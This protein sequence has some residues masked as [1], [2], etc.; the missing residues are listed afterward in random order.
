MIY[1][2]IWSNQQDILD[3][4]YELMPLLQQYTG[5]EPSVLTKNSFVLVYGKQYPLQDMD[6][7]WESN[8]AIL[9]GRIFDKVLHKAVEKKEFSK[10]SQKLQQGLTEEVW[11]KYVYW[12]IDN[13]DKIEVMTDPAGQLSCFYY[14]LPSGGLLF[15]SHIELIKQCLSSKLDYNW[16]YLCSYLSY[17]DSC[18]TQTPFK[19]IEEVPPGCLLTA[20]HSSRQ[21]RPFWNPF[22]TYASIPPYSGNAVDAL[23]A[24]LR[25]IT[26]PYQNLCVS[27]SGGL[28]SSSL[29]YCLNEIKRPEQKLTA[30]NYFH[31]SIK[32]SNELHY[33]RKICDELG[34]ELNEIDFSNTL[35]FDPYLETPSL[36]LN[37]PSSASICLASI[38]KI[39]HYFPSNE[40]SILLSGH[41]SDHIFSRPPVKRSLVD[42]LL[43]CGTRGL[44]GKIKYITHFYRDSFAPI[45]AQN[46][47]SLVRYFFARQSDKRGE[48][49]YKEKTPR[50]LMPKINQYITT[51]FVHP[52]YKD[53]PARILPGKYDQID[54]LYEA[55]AS[56]HAKANTY[57]PEH[58]PFLCEPVIHFALSFPTY[59]LFDKGYDRYPLRQAVSSRFKTDNVWRRDK[60]ET[61]GILQLGVK[62][63]IDYVMELCLEGELVK[64]GFVDKESLRQTILLISNGSY[65]DLW[66]FVQLASIEEFLRMWSLNSDKNQINK[67]AR[68]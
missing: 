29:V 38:N 57:N 52:V 56:I 46:M 12:N 41:G 53:V 10:Y 68:L 43:N 45:L 49:S 44:V 63:N 17:G 15:A 36:K 27:L 1:L 25:L 23:Q 20:T 24:V 33:A 54:A 67:Y 32:S 37:K 11:G 6:Q 59:D 22:A 60:G 40:S 9:V 58:Y 62:K 55:L 65:K 48:K 31:A 39:P 8:S 2:G 66:S 3:K 16:Q 28:D 5:E 19:D 14:V 35:P 34:I 50:W 13:T 21:V 61:T 26:E 18:A 4:I 47:M 42:Y 30:I 7:I 64:K 51:D